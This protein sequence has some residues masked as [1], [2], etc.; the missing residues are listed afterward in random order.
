MAIKNSLSE[1]LTL[2]ER[3]T[4]YFFKLYKKWPR[5]WYLT[6]L[7]W[8]QRKCHYQ[9]VPGLLV[10]GYDEVIYRGQKKIVKTKLSKKQVDELLL[11]LGTS[12][13]EQLQWVRKPAV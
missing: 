11:S 7:I 9:H 4:G 6:K 5:I 12:R 13:E 2:E 3:V 8:K 10:H 1:P